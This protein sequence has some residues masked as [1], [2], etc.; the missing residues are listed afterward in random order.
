MPA[1]LVQDTQMSKSRKPKSGGPAGANEPPPRPASPPSPG[2]APQFSRE[3]VRLFRFIAIMLPFLLLGGIEAAMRVFPKE[4]RDP[5]INISPV[6]VFSH[7]VT[8]GVE[9]YNI[10]HTNIL[11]GADVHIL[12]HKPANTFRVFCLGSSACAGWPH[13]RDETF[14]AYLQQALQTA[15]PGKTIEIINAAGHGFAAYRTRRV[16]D[17]AVK[18]DPDLLLVWEGNNEFL[19]D[20]NYTPPAAGLVALACKL[21]TVQW[22]R[23]HLTPRTTLN[24]SQLM[25]KDTAK[26][27][28]AKAHAQ[29]LK[30]RT[31]PV[32]YEQVNAHFRDS[33]ERMVEQAQDHRV[34]LILCTVPVNL[35][36]WVPNVSSNRLTGAP[37]EQWQQLYY[38]GRRGLLTGDFKVGIQAMQKAIAMDDQHAES[39]F[40]LGRLLEADG[41]RDAAWQAFSKARDLDLNPF[42]ATGEFNDIIKDIAAK[43]DGKGVYLLDLERIF[44]QATTNAAPGF[45]MFLDYVHPTKP[46]NF[47]VAKSVYQMIL[48]SGW[49]PG[50]PAVADFT[51]HEK[52]FGPHGEPYEEGMDPAQFIEMTTV[53]LD[54]RQLQMAL[55]LMGKLMAAKLGRAPTGP[56]DPLWADAAK[57]DGTAEFAEFRDRYRIVWHYLDVQRR[58]ILNQTVSEQE[59]REAKT[60][61]DAFYDREFPYGKL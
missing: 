41:Q 44:A 30:L 22:L 7:T 33:F 45:D 50:K 27:F 25:D 40:W 48:R 51:Y 28:Y 29:S 5:Y 38:A 1:G 8:N 53:A 26:F 23:D 10:T 4:D 17:E 31:D 15:Y 57:Q 16:L 58:L 12:A 32:Q 61:L 42:R 24:G 59:Q 46:A 37:L 13:A 56:D 39:Y 47:V 35:R 9:Y 52:P 3:R 18:L 6:S 14:S 43:N 60:Q 34:P 20:R 49:L 36:D 11:G 21:R 19:E 54:N 55:D 2:A